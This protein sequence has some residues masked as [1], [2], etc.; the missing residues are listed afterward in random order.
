MFNEI[1]ENLQLHEFLDSEATL[2]IITRGMEFLE[3][4][5]DVGNND[6]SLIKLMREQLERDRV[7]HDI[8]KMFSLIITFE[9]K[10]F[11]SIYKNRN[12][13][14]IIFYYLIDSNNEYLKKEISESLT[15]L[16]RE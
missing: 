16:T 8:F 6:K 12:L 10:R 11:R 3:Y 4:I 2:V 14:S 15:Y 5:S 7:V 13:K 9:N 1:C